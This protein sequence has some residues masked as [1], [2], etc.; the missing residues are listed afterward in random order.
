MRSGCAVAAALMSAAAWAQN[1][2]T[3]VPVDPTA[4]TAPAEPTAADEVTRLLRERKP[5]DAIKRA[6]AELAKNPRNAQVR[7]MRAVALT[8]VQRTAEAIAAFEAL[9]AEF[10]ELPEPYNNLAVLLAAAGKY[11]QARVLLL[12]SLDAQ[13]GYA[14]ALENLG[15]LYLAMAADAYQRANAR[16]PNDR[17]VQAKLALA[18]ETGTK[19]RA[20]K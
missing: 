18:R 7:F 12:R 5:E 1:A 20:I 11:E 15:D 14:T 13:P 9:N 3:T 16:N 4:A 10:P 17:V 6:D 2:P 19:L 8:D